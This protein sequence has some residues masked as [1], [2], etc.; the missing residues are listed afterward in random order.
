M[1]TSPPLNILR[2]G[3]NLSGVE[4][5]LLDLAFGIMEP[6]DA[7]HNLSNLGVSERWPTPHAVPSERQFKRHIRVDAVP[8]Q[9]PSQRRDS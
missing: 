2:F 6:D 7:C 3:I 4:S 1:L 5:V 9:M 8:Q